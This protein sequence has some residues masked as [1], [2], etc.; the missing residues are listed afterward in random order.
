MNPRYIHYLKVAIKFTLATTWAGVICAGSLT[1][2]HSYFTPASAIDVDTLEERITLNLQQERDNVLKHLSGLELTL[3]ALQEELGS[4]NDALRQV[5][6]TQHSHSTSINELTLDEAHIKELERRLSAAEKR[7]SE[8]HRVGRTSKPKKAEPKQVTPKVTVA[9]PPFVLFD[10]QKRGSV[11]LA[12]VGKADAKQLSELSAVRQGGHY[13]GWRLV[14]VEGN[15]VRVR[16]HAGQE[17][18]LEVDV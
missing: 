16:N 11:S 6:S 1:F 14:D 13:L 17:V 18:L 2:Y 8:P 15:Q 12:I 7:L 10:V 3:D 9:P 5:E 4:T